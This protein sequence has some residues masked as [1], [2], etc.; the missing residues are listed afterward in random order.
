MNRLQPASAMVRAGILVAGSWLLTAGAAGVAADAP[1][2]T[3]PDGDY[4]RTV[5]PSIKLLQDA[6]GGEVTR[7]SA[8]KARLAMLMLAE[9]AQ[10]NLGGP[11]GPQRAAMRD[12]ALEI[13]A[14]VKN[15]KYADAARQAKSLSRLPASKEAKKEKVKLLGPLLDVD[16]LM[17]Q[18]R[19]PDK[20]GLGIEDLLDKLEGAADGQVP[21]AA[22]NDE[23]RLLAYRTAVAAELCRDHMPPQKGQ[24]WRKLSDDMRQQ[25]GKLAESVQAKDGK[26][27]FQ[28]VEKL[29]SSCKACHREFR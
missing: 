16:E 24:L 27:A 6:L 17:G 23:L 10:Q 13:A 29:N 5:E 28:A 21:A 7:R 18:F 14:L 1:A 3:L 19:S 11:D 4:A 26:A 2:P 15:K 20:G 12:A 25:A 9:F 22:L 8:D